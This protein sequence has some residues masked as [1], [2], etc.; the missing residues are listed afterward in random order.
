MINVR[1]AAAAAI[2]LVVACNDLPGI[3]SG[4][5]SPAIE[6][7]SEFPLRGDASVPELDRAVDIAIS[8]HPM[9]DGY[10]LV[11]VTLDDSLAGVWN[12]ERAVQNMRRAVLESAIAGVVGPL[13]SFQAGYLIPLSSDSRLVVLS[14]SNTADC[15]TDR[16]APCLSAP[17]PPNTPTNYF[18]VAT[19]DT[20][21]ARAAADLAVHKL[22]ISRFAVL[23]DPYAPLFSQQMADAF[24]DKVIKAGGRIV[25]SQPFFTLETNF[26]PLLRDVRAAGAQSIFLS[27][28]VEPA[29]T[30][31]AQMQ[32]IFPA[33]AYL[34]SGDRLAGIG[35]IQAANLTGKTDDHFVLAIATGEPRSV[36]A[37]LQGLIRGH[38]YPIYTF[39]AYDCARILIDAID[40]AIRANGGKI[41]TREQVREAMAT[42]SNFR[43]LTGT[44]SFDA[45]GDVVNPS[46]SFY[47]VKQGSWAFWR[48][49]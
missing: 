15:V 33:D 37:D 43:G 38:G 46:L 20:L 3:G 10:R 48:N 4:P 49:P 2:L 32:G 45:S 22:G 44:Y 8:E 34:I 42:T 28:G 1:V 7:A 14:P 21:L 6:I 27:A 11:H 23:T 25:F 18:R 41:P 35:C 29:C 5:T 12:L 9:V 13:A 40:R 30:I 19:R 24:S 39:A 47:T 36:P 31:R 16:S 17:L 26:A